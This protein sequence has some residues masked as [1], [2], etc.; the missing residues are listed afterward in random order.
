MSPFFYV[1]RGIRK[2]IL[3]SVI[4][5]ILFHKKDNISFQEILYLYMIYKLSAIGPVYSIWTIIN[6]EPKEN[7]E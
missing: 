7:Q 1:I 6:C 3:V 5:E 4:W 2:N